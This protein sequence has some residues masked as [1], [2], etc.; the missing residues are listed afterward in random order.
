MNS[1]YEALLQTQGPELDGA[2]SYHTTVVA[3]QE[4]TSFLQWLRIKHQV[5]PHSHWAALASVW[6]VERVH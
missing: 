2:V 6:R 1:S 4:G 3:N 5:K